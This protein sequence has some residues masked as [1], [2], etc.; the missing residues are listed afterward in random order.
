MK[1][2]I[3]L[4][5]ALVMLVGLVACSGKSAESE[6]PAATTSTDGAATEAAASAD[7]KKVVKVGITGAVDTLNP[8]AVFTTGTWAT[9]PAYYER[10]ANYSEDN[11]ELTP[12]LAKGWT[13]V[14]D[15][16]YDVEIWDYITDWN[17]NKITADDVLFCYDSAVASGVI[18]GLDALDSVEKTGDYTL[19]FNLNTTEILALE[20]VLSSVDIVSQ[21]EYEA[22][23][24]NMASACVGT[25]RYIVKE[26]VPSSS[27]TLVKNENY[28]QTDELCHFRSIGEADEIHILTILEEAQLAVALETGTI[29]VAKISTASASSFIGNDAYDDF[30]AAST[31]YYYL[32]FNLG[33][34]S[35]FYKNQAL[36]QAICYAINVDDIVTGTY[37]GDGVKMSTIGLPSQAGYQESWD[38]ED[39]YDYDLD[40]AKQ[41]MA[42]AGYPDG[43]LT[44]R[45]VVLGNDICKSWSTIVQA[46]LSQIGIDLQVEALDSAVWY[47][48]CISGDFDICG[49]NVNRP[50][51]AVNLSASV[52]GA[53]Y[54]KDVET[55]P[56]LKEILE[57]EEMQQLFADACDSTKSTDELINAEH[58]MIK[59]KAYAYALVYPIQHTYARKE[60]NLKAP[61]YAQNYVLVPSCFQYNEK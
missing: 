13:Q 58:E 30:T 12:Q 45:L 50:H 23:S 20:T 36:R 29:D 2:I 3:A 27:M 46:Q 53:V 44:L 7:G 19:R 26:F 57:D 39:Y 38:S 40:K 55:T 59:D 8:F 60:L 10:L 22:S 18:V 25:G 1:K 37:R 47:T 17:G 49:F 34:N 14:D 16:T 54:Y 48:K 21:K 9:L 35:V 24:D 61:G 31:A 5:L 32:R 33:E 52:G 41:L 43:G 28:W 15:Y 51:I 11:S 42:E 6:A 4:L 56:Y